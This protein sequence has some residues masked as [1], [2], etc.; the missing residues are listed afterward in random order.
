HS[1]REAPGRQ[2]GCPNTAVGRMPGHAG[3]RCVTRISEA[4][5]VDARSMAAAL[6]GIGLLGCT[7]LACQPATIV[8]AQKEE[9]ARVGN[10]SQGLYRTT[11]TERL[12]PGEAASGGR[13]DWWRCHR[14]DWYRVSADVFAAADVD[15]FLEVCR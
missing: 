10:V 5:M 15:R 12:G 8:V 2:V 7:T 14:G 3:Q 9:R 1:R 4:I 11:G 13:G 6:V